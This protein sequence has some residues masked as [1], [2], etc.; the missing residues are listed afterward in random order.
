MH[1]LRAIAVLGLVALGTESAHAASCSFDAGSGL[2]SVST[3]GGTSTL[4]VVAGAVELD[5]VS[6]GA[7]TTTST[8][9][10]VVTGTGSDDD[11]LTL[12]GRFAPGRNDVPESDTA[13]IEIEVVGFDDE[14]DR[15]ILIGTTEDDVWRFT[16]G[17]I[18][19]NGDLDADIIAPLG[20]RIELR[21]RTGNDTIDASAYTGSCQLTLK[22]GDGDDTITGSFLNDRIFGEAGQDTLYGRAGADLIDDGAGTD[23]VYG[24]SGDDYFVQAVLDAATDTGDDLQGNAGIDTVSYIVRENDVTVSIDGIADD[25]EQGELDNVRLDVENVTSGSGD[26][27]LIGSSAANVLSGA[28]GNNELHGGSGDDWLNGGSG[29][30]TTINFVSGEAG[31]DYVSG[32]PGNDFLDGGPGDDEIEGFGGNDTLDGGPGI[33]HYLGGFGNDVF[34]NDDAQAET[35]DCGPGIDDP[36]PSAFD[37]F[38]RCELI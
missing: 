7:A 9:R 30:A 22:G 33:D 16:A 28:G 35:V 11:Q 36:E 15:L 29:D 18:N 13:E 19:L 27:V 20:G 5:G 24:G 38:I 6:C 32:S 25:G 3:V 8:S 31:D 21:P 2:L 17:G 34:Y 14:A 10:I 37:T 1:M 26:D 4:K 23:L 12:S